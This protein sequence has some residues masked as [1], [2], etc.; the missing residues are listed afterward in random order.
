MFSSSKVFLKR[1]LIES[2][3]HYLLI[4]LRS[5]QNLSII[6]Y[7]EE[8]I[9]SFDRWTVSKFRINKI[10][11]REKCFIPLCGKCDPHLNVR[12]APA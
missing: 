8:F 11:D 7:I 6:T 5:I 3:F 10:Y 12:G 1:Q 9:D 4:Y 2:P